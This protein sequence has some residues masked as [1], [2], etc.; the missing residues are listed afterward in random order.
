MTVRVITAPAVEPIT[1][2]EAKEHLR[3]DDAC[4]VAQDALISGLIRV[5]RNYAENYTRRAFVQ[6]TLEYT[7]HCFTHEMVLPRPPLISIESVKYIDTDGV[8]Q[9]VDSSV[10][11]I[12]SYRAPGLIKPAWLQYWPIVTRND[13]NAVRIR[14]V[15][16]YAPVGSPTDYASGV[17]EVIKQWMKIRL[18]NYHSFASDIVVGTIVANLQRD[19]CDALLDGICVD[20]F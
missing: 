7:T 20:L 10:Y 19:F 9:T 2:A 8:L 18:A 13:Y 16:G 4:G 15:A 17:P 1:L 6:Q 5:V 3:F 11:Q 12:D 14:Y